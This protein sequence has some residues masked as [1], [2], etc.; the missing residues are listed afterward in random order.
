MN[1]INEKEKKLISILDELKNLDLTNP[2]L[3][4]NIEYLR[5]QKNQLEI[6]KNELEIK[7]EE[8]LEE[9]GSL[10]KKLEEIKN[11]EKQEMRKQ[12]V[13]SEIIDELNQETDT[14]LEEIDKWET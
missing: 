11:K 7:Y 2:E 14:L 9:H 10:S 8:L 12:I 5:K 13:F 6:E 1:S 3:Q 4:N